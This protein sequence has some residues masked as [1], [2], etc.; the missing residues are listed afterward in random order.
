MNLCTRCLCA[1]HLSAACPI[2]AALTPEPKRDN[3]AW[4]VAPICA[5]PWLVLLMLWVPQ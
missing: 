5:A 4:F 1:G 3:R 2:V